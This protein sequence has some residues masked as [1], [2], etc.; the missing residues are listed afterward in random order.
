VKTSEYI[1]RHPKTF[2]LILCFASL[3][4]IGFLDYITGDEI[5]LSVFYLFPVSLAVWR[6][7]KWMGILFCFLSAI[8][9][10]LADVM[11]GH[12][13]SHFLIPYWNA[14]VRLSFF[15]IVTELLVKLRASLEHEKML[16]MT[17]SLTRLLNVRAF[18]DL[19]NLEID[20]ARR[21]KR[22][23]TL[24]Y[25]DLDNFKMVNDQLGH[26]VGDTLLRS[27]A[28][29][30]KNNTR[31]INLAARLGGD[32][33]AILLAETGIESAQTVFTRLQEKIMEDMQRNR[34]PVTLSIG[35]ITFNNPPD[36]VDDM[37]RKADNL[38]YKAKNN[39]KNKILLEQ[40]DK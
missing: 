38:M 16:S 21:F 17:D 2:Y 5:S 18:Y 7:N 8:V 3:S 23:L 12:V 35:S 11:A 4:V 28:D 30:I 34:W 31:V 20:R 22:P 36:S 39:G 40:V 13:Y 27:V 15:L 33:F 6:G 24:G 19:A 1:G 14:F 26:S 9:W 25:I 32:E 37:V 29:I 10:F